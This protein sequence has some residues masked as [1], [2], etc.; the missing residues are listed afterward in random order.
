MLPAH[1]DAL[2]GE[3]FLRGHVE[4]VISTCAAPRIPVRYA[5]GTETLRT[6]PVKRSCGNGRMG[7]V[8]RFTIAI[9]NSTT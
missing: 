8:K 4:L 5:F 9:R 7:L 2:R 3:I 1:S 6:L